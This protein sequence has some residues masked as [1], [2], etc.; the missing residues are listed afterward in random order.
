MAIL[1][2]TDQHWRD[3]LGIA[4]DRAP[5]AL[6]MEGT[7]WRQAATASRLDY[8]DDVVELAFPDMFMGKW[9]GLDVAF[10][11]AYGA[12]R[13]V[14]PT[15]IFSQLG[16]DLLIQIGTCGSLD[17]DASTGVVALPEECLARDGVSQHYGAGES[18]FTDAGLVETVEKSLARHGVPS[19]RTRHLTWPSLFAQSDEMCE[20]WALEGIASIDMETSAVVAVG[21]RFGART[22]SMLTVW[23]QLF[24]GRTFNDPLPE[25]DMEKLKRANKIV[26][27]VALELALAAKSHPPPIG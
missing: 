12:P 5:A 10:C 1:D 2:Y 6:I 15:H 25:D 18:V 7:W 11:C 8:L 9:Q 23:D 16:T 14:E 24:A 21:D 13:A 26:F 4:R 3:A 20:R 19:Q 27:E 22:V 17:A